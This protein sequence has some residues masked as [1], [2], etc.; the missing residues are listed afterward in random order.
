[1]E[2]IMCVV[3]H[4]KT[5]K[6]LRAATKIEED[7]PVHTY[8]WVE[9]IIYASRAPGVKAAEMLFMY[10][11]KD[12]KEVSCEIVEVLLSVTEVE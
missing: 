7:K 5:G 6:Y 1:M 3:K 11:S 2:R 9:D 4:P 12:L 10:A 8:T